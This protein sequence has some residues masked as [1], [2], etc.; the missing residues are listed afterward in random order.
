MNKQE[1]RTN[2]SG[3]AVSLSPR[4]L[5]RKRGR[6]TKRGRMRQRTISSTKN[7]QARPLN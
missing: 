5:L 2:R 3:K 7:T 1:R 4:F 6:A